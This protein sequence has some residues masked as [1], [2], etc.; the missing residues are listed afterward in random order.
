[1][2]MSEADM[3]PVKADSTAMGLE[4]AAGAC[5]PCAKRFAWIHLDS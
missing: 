3:A 2:A 1:M 5:I 4:D